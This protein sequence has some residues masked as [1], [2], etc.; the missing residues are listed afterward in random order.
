MYKLFKTNYIHS[1]KEAPR[2]AKEVERKIQSDANQRKQRKN[3][4]KK[5]KEKESKQ[6]TELKVAK[7]R[8]K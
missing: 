2:L 5:E 8:L 1:C 7:D 4:H 3:C 6:R